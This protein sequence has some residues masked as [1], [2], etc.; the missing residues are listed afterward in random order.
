MQI[1]DEQVLP[2]V[3]LVDFYPAVMLILIVLAGVALCLRASRKGEGA[4]GVLY[5]V[6]F[7]L[8]LYAAFLL[9]LKN[10]AQAVDA[11]VP[12]YKLFALREYGYASVLRDLLSFAAP[13]LVA[14]ALI[15]PAF[16]QAG[17][18]AALLA[19]TFSALA[20]N[21]Y[22]LYNGMAFV[23]D[24]YLY[25]GIGCATGAA[26][27]AIL[28]NLLKKRLPL[29]RLRLPVP[30]RR[31]YRAALLLFIAVYFGVALVMVFDYGEPYAP[32][33]FFDSETALPKNIALNCALSEEAGRANIYIPSAA[34]PAE[35]AGELAEEL[36]IADAPIYRD[37]TYIADD[38]T[39]KLTLTESGSWVYEAAAA[40][41]GELPTQESA[42]DAVFA[43]FAERRLIA[44][45]LGAVTDIVAHSATDGAPKG[46]DVYLSTSVNGMPIV[47][48]S[49]LVVSVRAGNAVTKI[50]RYDGDVLPSTIVNIISQ[51]KAYEKIAS[52][53]CAYTLFTPASSAT[54]DGCRL[55]YMANSSQGYYLPVW[56]FTCAAQYEDGTAGVF[57][58][59]VE[60]MK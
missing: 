18:F 20:F 10:T 30:L 37:G 55:I 43:F 42:E 29:D 56:M 28:A 25:A 15:V 3:V 33:Q 8:S 57:Y 1:N 32:I 39:A 49:T 4:Y 41:E 44:A 50:R 6:L 21:V 26:V 19:G 48:S 14:G 7:T 11:F 60:A 45:E 53:D 24:E 47:G 5:V 40:P 46:Y 51:Q 59:Y 27:Y 58:I 38:G 17:L 12:F 9:K 54:V 31:R 22:P 35:K 36:G 23:T 52:G 2:E 16:P 13:F 34:S